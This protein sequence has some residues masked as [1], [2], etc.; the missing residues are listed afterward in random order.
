MAR[1]RYLILCMALA[2]AGPVQAGVTK[3]LYTHSGSATMDRSSGST[4]S[5]FLAG[6]G[7]SISFALT[8]PIR[9]AMVLD[10]STTIDFYFTIARDA[11]APIT[12]SVDISLTCSSCSTTTL[13]TLT[14]GIAIMAVAGQHYTYLVSFTLAG[15]VTVNAGSAMTL[16][17]TNSTS[18]AGKGLTFHDL[19]SG[20]IRSRVELDVTAATAITIDSTGT[21]SD[22]GCSSSQTTFQMGDTV[23]VCS[24]VS[25]PFG[26]GDI[27]QDPTGGPPNTLPD[28]SIADPDTNTVV[29]AQDMTEI[30]D[31]S[32]ATRTFRYAYTIPNPTGISEGTFDV[33]IVGAYEGTEYSVSDTDTA[34][35]SFIRPMLTITKTSDATDDPLGNTSPNAYEVPGSTIAYTV[36]IENNGGGA[37]ADVYLVDPFDSNVTLDPSGIELETF[38]TGEGATPNGACDGSSG[39]T[40]NYAETEGDGSTDNGTDGVVFDDTNDELE[41]FADG[42]D[43]L[44]LPADSCLE[45]RFRVTID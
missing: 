6:A 12:R 26:E 15:P 39:G 36:V 43:A 2:V 23:Y 11:N 32:N 10:T 40:T 31:A 33:S 8:P 13:G 4:G 25:D 5:V 17:F 9:R 3:P 42:D 20:G 27:N 35:F 14:G 22:T 45:I 44:T 37:A 18:A 16:T 30:A 38:G 28:I 19:S 41:F 34:S 1:M 29:N 7:G 21:F 24:V